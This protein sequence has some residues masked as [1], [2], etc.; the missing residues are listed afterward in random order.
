MQAD[1]RG[2]V[3]MQARLDIS[4]YLLHVYTDQQW[5][6]MLSGVNWL[7]GFAFLRLVFP[8]SPPS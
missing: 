3:C 4:K 2:T 6:I 7:C 1:R 5:G 8:L